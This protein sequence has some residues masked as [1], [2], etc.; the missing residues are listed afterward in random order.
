MACDVLKFHIQVPKKL[1]EILK[2]N[3]ILAKKL[4]V[5]IHLRLNAFTF[6]IITYGLHYLV[7]FVLTITKSI[8]CK[9]I[10]FVLLFCNSR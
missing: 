7:T 10:V 4:L 3:K 5:S 1:Y 9:T 6:Y 2:L 8:D